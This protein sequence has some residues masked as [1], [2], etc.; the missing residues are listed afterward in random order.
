MK[1]LKLLMSISTLCLAIMVLCFGVFSATNITYTMGGT[2]SYEVEDVYCKITTKVYKRQAQRTEEQLF[3]DIVDELSAKSF[4]SID[5]TKYTLAED[6]G[7]YDSYLNQGTASATGI[8]I[9]FGKETS[10]GNYYYTYYIVINVSNLSTITDMYAVLID[11]NT[12]SNVYKVCKYS[13]DKILKDDATRNIV[14]AYSLIDIK[15]GTNLTFNYSLEVKKGEL[16]SYTIDCNG[17]L[18]GKY[19][20]GT[21]NYGKFKFYV[22]GILPY[23][24]ESDDFYHNLKYGDMWKIEIVSVVS[25]KEFVGLRLNGIDYSKMYGVVGK[26]ANYDAVSTGILVIIN[27]KS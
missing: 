19:F 10:S 7:S 20:G 11:D 13:Q 6:K 27:T 16:Q 15:Q 2:V 4:D 25:G 22:N 5:T 12:E 26:W 18:D 17:Y 14:I 23:G 1:K 9:N 3:D 21:T 8:N 24:G